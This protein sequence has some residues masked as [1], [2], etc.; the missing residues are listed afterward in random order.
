MGVPCFLSSIA[1]LNLHIKLIHTFKW[2]Q[3]HYV[4]VIV[5]FFHIKNAHCCC[6]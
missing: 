6:A 5:K 3:M 1:L 4:L 2:K